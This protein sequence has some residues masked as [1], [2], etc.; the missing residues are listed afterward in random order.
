MGVT[1][2]LCL[3]RREDARG[4]GVKER[5]GGEVRGLGGGVHGR[6]AWV[7]TDRAAAA[8]ERARGGHVAWAQAGARK[9]C[10]AAISRYVPCVL[11]RTRIGGCA[12]RRPHRLEAQ[13][14][15][16]SRR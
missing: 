15:G 4:D 16:F 9:T 11:E 13:D 7:W 8:M 12:H 14:R 10:S 1:F 3:E 6:L 5:E 2:E